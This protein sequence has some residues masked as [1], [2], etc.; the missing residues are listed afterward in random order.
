MKPVVDDTVLGVYREEEGWVMKVV[1][2]VGF[3]WL[4]WWRVREEVEALALAAEV[5]RELMMRIGVADFVG[6]WLYY[7]TVIVGMVRIVKGLIGV[8]MFLVCNCR[9]RE[10]GK[11]TPNDEMV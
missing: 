11:P 3:G 6:W 7:I 8:S 1:I 4:W 5:R 10:K 2:G 9:R